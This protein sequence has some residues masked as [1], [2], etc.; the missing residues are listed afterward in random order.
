MRP[1]IGQS[2]IY[3]DPQRRDHKA[4]VTTVWGPDCVNVV[5]VSFDEAK[6]DQYGRQIERETSV[7]RFNHSNCYGRCF[8]DLEV[9]AVFKDT[10]AAA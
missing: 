8:R 2:V 3:T 1:E 7:G 5:Y 4:L 9:V 6:Q 10:P